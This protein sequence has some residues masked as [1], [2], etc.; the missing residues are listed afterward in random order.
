M[1]SEK[2]PEKSKKPEIT[3]SGNWA[4]GAIQ[5]SLYSNQ[6]TILNLLSQSSDAG[7]AKILFD[8]TW[9]YV[10]YPL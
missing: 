6:T 10:F 8:G 4:C 9:S 3:K 7:S 5:G 2:E 1:K